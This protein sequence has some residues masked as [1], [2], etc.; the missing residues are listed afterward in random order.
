MCKN[1][2]FQCTTGCERVTNT[3]VSERVNG[4]RQDVGQHAAREQLL[5]LDNPGGVQGGT[6]RFRHC[7]GELLQ[8]PSKTKHTTEPFVWR[9]AHYSITDN[10]I[11]IEVL[12][13]RLEE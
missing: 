8:L 11:C 10:L 6:L 13:V 9:L 2:S 1:I 3:P 5:R 7:G 4:A 12:P